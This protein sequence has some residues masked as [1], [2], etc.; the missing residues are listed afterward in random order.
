[1]EETLLN[2]SERAITLILKRE[3]RGLTDKEEAELGKLE[4]FLEAYEDIFMETHSVPR[5]AVEAMTMKTGVN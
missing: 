3:F 4:D 1:M 5:N 2:L